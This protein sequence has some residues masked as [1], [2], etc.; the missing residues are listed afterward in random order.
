MSWVGL[1]F[2]YFWTLIFGSADRLQGLEGDSTFSL[3]G[4]LVLFVLWPF[5]FL[6]LVL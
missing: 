4:F 1:V 2:F 3:P 6:W 5:V